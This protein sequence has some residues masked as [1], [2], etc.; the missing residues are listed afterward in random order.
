MTQY[1]VAFVHLLE[2]K[3]DE[4]FLSSHWHQISQVTKQLTMLLA[5]HSSLEAYSVKYRHRPLTL[6]NETTFTFHVQLLTEVHLPEVHASFRLEPGSLLTESHS[7]SLF[8]HCGTANVLLVCL[9]SGCLFCGAVLVVW[10][11]D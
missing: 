8:H 4:L 11:A 3:A 9:V 2:G 7:V 6:H 10:L 5:G 1:R